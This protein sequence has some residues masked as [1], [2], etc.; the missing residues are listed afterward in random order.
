MCEVLAE[1]GRKMWIVDLTEGACE[2]ACELLRSSNKRG[3]S[4]TA[5]SALEHRQDPGSPVGSRVGEYSV[6]VSRE[7]CLARRV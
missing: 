3:K 5:R 1:I 7:S 2:G 6:S 4:V